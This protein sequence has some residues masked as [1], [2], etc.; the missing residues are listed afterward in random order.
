ML[1][2]ACPLCG[3]NDILEQDIEDLSDSVLLVKTFNRIQLRCQNCG[4]MGYGELSVSTVSTAN[5]S[6]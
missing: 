4:W 6:A 3:D 1:C 2:R 5:R